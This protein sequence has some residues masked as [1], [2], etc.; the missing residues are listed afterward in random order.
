MQEKTK[1]IPDR[2][3]RCRGKGQHV[4]EGQQRR[5]SVMAGWVLSFWGRV[6]VQCQWGTGEY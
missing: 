6:P 2:G 4:G 5:G 3:Y 1:G